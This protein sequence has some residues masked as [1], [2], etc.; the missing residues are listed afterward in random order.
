MDILLYSKPHF[1]NVWIITTISQVSK[2]FTFVWYTF[3]PPHEKTSKMT[4]APSEDTGQPG[5]PPSLIRIFAVSMKKAWVLS[6]PL[7]AQQSLWSDWEVAQADL[8]LRWVHMPFYWF[9]HE[10]AQNFQELQSSLS[11]LQ[12]WLSTRVNW[13]GW[14]AMYRE[15]LFLSSRGCWRTLLYSPVKLYHLGLF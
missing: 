15:I 1:P 14:C 3:E 12:D 8:S 7:S 9:C 10:V 11:L 4:C 6:Y 13:R 5:H 2:F